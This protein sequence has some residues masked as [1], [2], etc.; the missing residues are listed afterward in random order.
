MECLDA[1]HLYAQ[2]SLCYSPSSEANKIK[3]FQSNLRI[4][5]IYPVP[6]VVALITSNKKPL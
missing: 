6:R 3:T 1:L 2:G 5:R 4:F